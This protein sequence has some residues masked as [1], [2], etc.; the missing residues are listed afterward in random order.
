MGDELTTQ[1][2][3]ILTPTLLQ[4]CRSFIIAFQGF[5][6][7]LE[8]RNLVF[9]I[10][11]SSARSGRE[12]RGVSVGFL[13]LAYMILYPYVFERAQ[14]LVSG[15]QQT[16][17]STKRKFQHREP[18]SGS[19]VCSALILTEIHGNALISGVSNWEL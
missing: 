16:K 11:Y 7:L 18:D 6:P 10:E 8:C 1:G 13:E 9:G 3:S 14:R 4:R 17:L 2:T 12:G 15:P 5:Q 19:Y